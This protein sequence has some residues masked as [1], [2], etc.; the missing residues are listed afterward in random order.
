MDHPLEMASDK[1][2]PPLRTRQHT[3]LLL[4]EGAVKAIVNFCPDDLDT[5][6]LVFH[7]R[8]NILKV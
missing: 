6:F 1:S 4:N 7:L 3:R 2:Y 8:R 5:V